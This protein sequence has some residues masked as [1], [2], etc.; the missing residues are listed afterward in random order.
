M[1]GSKL[2]L[3]LSMGYFRMQ[4]DIFT[5]QFVPFEN[6]LCPVYWLRIALN[7]V[8]YGPKQLRLLRSNEKFSV[9]VTPFALSDELETLYA[10]Y[11]DSINFEAPES[12][13]ACL[14]ESSS[15]YNAF[16]TYVVEVRDANR[17]I[18]AGVFD[19][20]L[21]SIAGIMNFYHPD[22]RKYSLGKYLMLQ[23][24][25][26]ARRQ[27]KVYYYPGYIAYNY[28]KFD[29]KT[30]PCEAATELLHVTSGLWIPFTWDTLKI[31]SVNN[32]S[33]Y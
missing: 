15:T 22:Y 2:D 19:N 10:Q 24:I 13:E 18:A 1:R 17:L 7:D 23:K 21:Q 33:E 6:R 32:I 28:S 4:Q 26:Y 8:A 30:F 20:G 16:D 12:V 5:C 27:R 9:S 29:Y 31:L 25:N 3:C 11:K 14:L